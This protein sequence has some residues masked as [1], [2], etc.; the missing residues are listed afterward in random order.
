VIR[1]PHPAKVITGFTNNELTSHQAYIMD[2]AIQPDNPSPGG[3]REEPLETAEEHHNNNVAFLNLFIRTGKESA[4]QKAIESGKLAIQNTPN[5]DPLLTRR[6]VDLGI[7]LGERFMITKDIDDLDEAI[8]IGYQALKDVPESHDDRALIL[9]Y[10]CCKIGDRFAHMGNLKDAYEAIKF[11]K[12]AIN[13]ALNHHGRYV[14]ILSNLSACYGDLFGS[15]GDLDHSREAIR[16]QQLA[17]NKL[18]AKH[19]DRGLALYDLGIRFRHQYM[20]TQNLEDLQQAIQAGESAIDEKF[21]GEYSSYADCISH[22]A[23]CLR[24]RYTRKMDIQDLEKAIKL[25]YSG[26]ALNHLPEFEKAKFHES[27]CLCL[28]DQFKSTKLPTYIEQAIH[29]G[30]EAL[31][32]APKASHSQVICLH[33]VSSCYMTRSRFLSPTDTEFIDEAIKYEKSAL[34][35]ALADHPDTAECVQSLGV[36]FLNRAEISGSVNDIEDSI[37][38][39][40]QS[41]HHTRGVP[42]TRMTAGIMAA[43]CLAILTKWTQSSAVFEEVLQILPKISPRTRAKQDMQHALQKLSGAACLAASVF[44]KSG[45]APIEA[46]Q[47]LEQGRGIIASLVID[48][49]SEV[50]TLRDKHEDLYSRFVELR[51]TVSSPSIHQFL[52]K[53]SSQITSARNIQETLRMDQSAADLDK[54]IAEI[55]QK[56]GFETFLDAFGERDILQLA[57]S[58]PIVYYNISNISAEAFIITKDKVECLP[59]PEFKAISRDKMPLLRNESSDWVRRD[60]KVLNSTGTDNDDAIEIQDASGNM[61]SAMQLLWSQAIEPVLA[62]LKLLRGEQTATNLLP[63]VWWIGGGPM[64]RLPLHAAGKHSNGATDNTISHVIS[65]YATTLKSLQFARDKAQR[66]TTLEGSKL[67]VVTMPVTPGLLGKLNVEKEVEAIQSAFKSPDSITVLSQPSK[68]QV[69]QEFPN[70][71]ICHFACHGHADPEDPSNSALFLGNTSLERLTVKDLDLF[72]HTG[73]QIAYLSACSTAELTTRYLIDE[74]IHLA[75]TFLLAGFPHVIGTLWKAED[76][77]A[78]EVAGEFYKGFAQ[79]TEAGD[80]FV[81]TALHCAILKLRNSNGNVGDISKWAPFV[82]MGA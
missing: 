16:L 18:G 31:A 21:E 42:L 48:S 71:T 37:K 62:R 7:C 63:R 50:T 20:R 36:Y 33:N 39:T 3:H 8:R 14:Q 34:E 29:H 45:R 15:T 44:L 2:E 25:G 82:H 46:L 53:G 55:R 12:L 69:L 4:L 17:V 64:T 19:A 68:S 10:V 26:L 9:Q 54:I 56:P 1:L 59:L 40:L 6:R 65:S 24:Y 35:I 30:L 41:L 22:Y 32:I 77:A 78:V 51:D 79:Q 23:E 75:S 73:A 57:T 43:S 60:A 28:H 13:P 66:L 70:C 74:S 27:L 5:D 52:G 67:L 76:N 72:H 80:A 49:R 47:I 58:G 38:Y 61:S 11:G 81:A